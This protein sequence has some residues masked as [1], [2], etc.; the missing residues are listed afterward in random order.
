MGVF[1]SI[2][3]SQAGRGVRH[4]HYCLITWKEA[5]WTPPFVSCLFDSLDIMN[6]HAK[7]FRTFWGWNH[8]LYEWMMHCDYITSNDWLSNFKCSSDQPSHVCYQL[9]T[10]W[11]LC[12]VWKTALITKL[13]VKWKVLIN[14]A[15][16]GHLSC[17]GLSIRPITYNTCYGWMVQWGLDIGSFLA[18]L[19]QLIIHL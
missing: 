1:C 7:L 6:D 9:R 5:L 17:T 8:F 12:T 18:L 16:T 13:S 10:C 15:K 4:S 19:G 11:I 3:E 2:F 14:T